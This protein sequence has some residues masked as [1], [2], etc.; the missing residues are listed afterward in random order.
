MKIK[1]IFIYLFLLYAGCAK[2]PEYDN[3][4][5]IKTSEITE[6][7]IDNFFLKNPNQLDIIFLF[8]QVSM[9]EEDNKY[10]IFDKTN[11]YVSNQIETGF[12]DKDSQ[13]TVYLVAKLEEYRFINNFYP[14]SKWDKLLLYIKQG[15]YAYICE[16]IVGNSNAL[17]IICF[18][19]L[20][21]IL[22]VIAIK[23]VLQK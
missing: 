21:I 22:I 11:R 16:R 10:V 1:L 8:G 13:S 4:K 20:L 19:G 15:R 3:P 2:T 17:F 23:K 9:L 12:F 14:P 5:C 18:F 7:S 6:Q